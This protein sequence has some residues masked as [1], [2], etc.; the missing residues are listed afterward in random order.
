MEKILKSINEE[1]K[2]ANDSSTAEIKFDS[3]IFSINCFNG[4]SINIDSDP[5]NWKPLL[6]TTAK[7][8]KEHSSNDTLYQNNTDVNVK[9]KDKSD[10]EIKQ[11]IIKKLDWVVAYDHGNSL[12]ESNELCINKIRQSSINN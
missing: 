2:Q 10:I 11:E 12:K 8:N 1:C 6:I 9:A 4:V 5:R 3:K 7:I